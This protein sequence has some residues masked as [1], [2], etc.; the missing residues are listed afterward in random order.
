MIIIRGIIIATLLAIGT[1]VAAKAPNNKFGWG[2]E[3][4]GNRLIVNPA[5]SSYWTPDEFASQNSAGYGVY[6]DYRWRKFGVELGYS[7]IENENFPG[8]VAKNYDFYLD[9]FYYFPLRNDFELKALLGMALLNTYT[10]GN[11]PLNIQGY[12]RSFALHAGIGAQKNFTENFSVGLMYKF[13]ATA[14]NVT[15]FYWYVN[16]IAI[17][18]TWYFG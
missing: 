1:S 14:Q 4:S 15:Q 10:T 17:Y 12:Y 13:I 7:H 5:V 16:T 9:W 8:F 18:G 2:L 6:V 11:V 3:V